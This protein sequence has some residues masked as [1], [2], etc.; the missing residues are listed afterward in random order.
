MPTRMNECVK[1][2]LDELDPEEVQYY[3]R[4]SRLVYQLCY[5]R[6]ER[7]FITSM[8]FIYW[9]ACNISP[10]PGIGFHLVLTDDFDAPCR[11]EKVGSEVY[12]WVKTDK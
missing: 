7:A 12:D 11:W 3:F 10:R 9:A 1:K 4:W 2:K 6:E 8:E 5:T